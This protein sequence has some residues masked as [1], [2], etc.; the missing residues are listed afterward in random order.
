MR[1]DP[2]VEA[3]SYKQ[4]SRSVSESLLLSLDNSKGPCGQRVILREAEKKRRSR[5]AAEIKSGK[6]QVYDADLSSYFDTI[7]HDKLFLALRRRITDS[8]VLSLI[9]QW[10]KSNSVEPNGVQNS[11]KGRGTPQ[12]GVISPLL[13]NIY[14][15]WFETCAMMV[16]KARHYMTGRRYLEWCPSPKSVKKVRRKVKEQTMRR[17][18]LM[19]VEE[20]IK[21]QVRVSVASVCES[22]RICTVSPVQVPQQEEAA[23]VSAE[24]RRDLLRRT[25]ETR[26]YS[27]YKKEVLPMKSVSHG[28]PCVGN[29]HARFEDGASASKEPRR[30]A[31]LHKCNVK[32]PDTVLITGASSG[33]GEALAVECAKRGTRN[34]FFCGRDAERVAAVVRKCEAVAADSVSDKPPVIRGEV[35]DVT[36]EE[37]VRKWIE[38]CNAAAPLEVVF[39]NAGIGTGIENEENVRRTFATNVGGNLN[40][41]L[42]TIDIFR[43]K[44]V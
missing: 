28:K 30:N 23:A 37:A 27:P 40:V 7:P 42:P 10:L 12:G 5:F 36:D 38:E 18:L 41:V 22:E 20:V 31:L 39:S 4:V 2:N 16:A 26:A 8:G 32:N 1:G 13:S 9:R 19:P 14:L 6:N 25:K 35:L 43:R 17:K 24:I 21:R 44:V 34:I 15:H 3:L 11:P 29:P 33:I